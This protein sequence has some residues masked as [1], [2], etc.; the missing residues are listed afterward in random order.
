MFDESA[1]EVKR[2]YLTYHEHSS[3][4]Q[5]I[6]TGPGQKFEPFVFEL[7][8]KLVDMKI[9]KSRTV[10]S[11]ITMIAEV[12]GFADLFVVASTFL[13]GQLHT[14]NLQGYSLAKHASMVK[15]PASR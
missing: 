6:M 8:A 1:E 12:S 4:N 14:S 5:K 7:S 3:V 15:L 9:I 13:L 2:S 11:L 10:Y